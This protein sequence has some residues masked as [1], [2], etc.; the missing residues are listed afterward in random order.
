[1]NY[2]LSPVDTALGLKY[3]SQTL[4]H[5]VQVAGE[6]VPALGTDFDGFT[7]P[8]DEIIDISQLPRLTRYLMAE[9]RLSEQAIGRILGGNTLALIRRGWGRT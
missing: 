5:I 7:D 2:W 9:G 6:G 8:P 4:H 1:M 3:I